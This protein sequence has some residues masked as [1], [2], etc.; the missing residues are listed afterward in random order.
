[1][2]RTGGTWQRGNGAGWGG[3]ARG[4]GNGNPLN[5]DHLG[6]LAH[7]EQ[8]DPQAKSRGRVEKIEAEKAAAG[9]YAKAMELLAK[10]LD[11]VAEGHADASLGELAMVVDKTGNRAFGQPKGETALSGSGL[12]I[13]VVKRGS[14]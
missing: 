6:R 11:R 3:P 8:P 7:A 1:M 2:P 12:V 10:R 4:A 5:R 13:N 9:V 14:D